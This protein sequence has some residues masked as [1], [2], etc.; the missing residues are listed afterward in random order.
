MPNTTTDGQ[1]TKR[2]IYTD[3][4]LF[5]RKLRY[6][7]WNVPPSLAR[8]VNKLWTRAVAREQAKYSGNAIKDRLS[9]AVFIEYT[10]YDCNIDTFD[11]EDHDHDG[12]PCFTSYV[13]EH[14]I[15]MFN[16]D[17]DDDDLSGEGYTCCINGCTRDGIDRY[18]YDGGS[19]LPDWA[20]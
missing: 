2:E 19:A 10:E 14:H 6:A 16:L 1:P 8:E 18:N 7:D 5:L 3:M 9:D 20:R 15:E 17:A 12:D 13:C 11:D 4:V